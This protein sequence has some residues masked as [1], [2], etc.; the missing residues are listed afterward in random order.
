MASWFWNMGLGVGLSPVCPI[1]GL[2]WMFLSDTRLGSAP[3]PKRPENCR[4][5]VI[6]WQSVDAVR[7][8]FTKAGKSLLRGAREALIYA[9]GAREGFVARKP[10]RQALFLEE[11]SDAELKAISRAEVPAEYGHLNIE[12]ESQGLGNRAA[13]ARDGHFLLPTCGAANMT[14]AATAARRPGPRSSF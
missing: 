13:P 7:K 8:K 14:R 4:T 1:P 6:R 9:R 3:L 2:F 5:P 11:L 10:D 12:C